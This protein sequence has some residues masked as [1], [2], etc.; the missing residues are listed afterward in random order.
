MRDGERLESTLA[1]E[2]P[3]VLFHL[4]AYKHVDWAERFPAEFVDT[5]LR[6]SW[7][8]L[9]AS[10]ASAVQTVVVASTDKA[11]LAASLYARTKRLMEQLTADAGGGR[12]AA[13]FVNVLDSAGSASELFLRQARGGVPLTITDAGMVRYWITMGHATCLAAHAGLLATAGKRLAAPADPVTMTVGELAARIWHECGREGGPEV[14]AIGIR[15]GETM[16][17]V[18][19]GPGEDLTDEAHQGVAA[20]SGGPGTSGAAWVAERLTERGERPEDAN[21][22]WLEALG[23]PDLVESETLSNSA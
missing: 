5:N 12:I 19:T 11:A 8:V 4:A 22:V 2:R 3:D 14:T 7:N 15:D 16:A 18:L 21:E 10:E 20:I 9:R 6:G 1:A 17:E 23:R 13:R